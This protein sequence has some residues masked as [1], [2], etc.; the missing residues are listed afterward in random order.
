MGST[1]DTSTIN[2][3]IEA[4]QTTLDNFPSE[5]RHHLHE[6]QHRDEH[7]QCEISAGGHR[8]T[9]TG[10]DHGLVFFGSEPL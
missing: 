8:V 2:D 1:V 6:M 9:C 10:K 7:I 3:V 4:L 5:I